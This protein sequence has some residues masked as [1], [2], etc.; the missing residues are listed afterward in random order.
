MIRKITLAAIF[1]FSLLLMSCQERKNDIKFDLYWKFQ[2][3]N[4]I[5]DKQTENMSF[6]LSSRKIEK[7]EVDSLIP[8]LKQRRWHFYITTDSSVLVK[9]LTDDIIGDMKSLDDEL[10][11]RLGDTTF[12]RTFYR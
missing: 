6:E 7:R 9:N 12:N 1:S 3:V 2:H 4:S 5:V 10:Y 11:T 8:I